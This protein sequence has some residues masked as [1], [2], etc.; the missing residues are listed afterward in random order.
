MLV[1][2]N[3]WPGFRTVQLTERTH[4]KMFRDFNDKKMHTTCRSSTYF[5]RENCLKIDFNLKYAY[6]IL[7]KLPEALFQ[8]TLCKSIN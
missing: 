7:M 3:I 2:R 5:S 6:V 4:R 1:L 8:F